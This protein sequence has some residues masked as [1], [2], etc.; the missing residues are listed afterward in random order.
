MNPFAQQLIIYFNKLIYRDSSD[1]SINVSKSLNFSY[2]DEDFALLTQRYL[3]EAVWNNPRTLTTSCADRNCSYPSFQSISWCPRCEDITSDVVLQG[4][5][6]PFNFGPPR[7]DSKSCEISASYGK[8]MTMWN[9]VDSAGPSEDGFEGTLDLGLR[10]IWEIHNGFEDAIDPEVES[11]SQKAFPG[12]RHSA[13]TIVQ[14][15]LHYDTT[16]PLQALKIKHAID[17]VMNPCVRQYTVK[18]NAEVTSIQSFKISDG[19]VA[20]IMNKMDLPSPP[21]RLTENEVGAKDG[22]LCWMSNYTFLS[23]TEYANHEQ[24]LYGHDG[25]ISYCA[26]DTIFNRCTIDPQ[27]ILFDQFLVKQRDPIVDMLAGNTNTSYNVKSELPWKDFT[28]NSSDGI[29]VDCDINRTSSYTLS[30]RSK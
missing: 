14:V 28:L 19:T 24:S 27:F 25:W 21:L 9:S 20:F 17:C 18:T 13:S 12:E 30:V 22:M 16:H 8:Q 15:D 6:V 26:N 4:C 3:M 10:C 29:S 1:A 2:I 7:T 5:D 11:Q 23:S